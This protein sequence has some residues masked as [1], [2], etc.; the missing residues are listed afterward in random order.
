MMLSTVA[1]DVSGRW[2]GLA[3][4]ASVSLVDSRDLGALPSKFSFQELKAFS[5]D[6]GWV[7][8][9]NGRGLYK[10]LPPILLV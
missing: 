1:V 4:G 7:D 10:R 5:Q 3:M 9:A 8:A 2:T 6:G